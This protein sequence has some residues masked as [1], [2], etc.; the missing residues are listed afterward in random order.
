MG[1]RNELMLHLHELCSTHIFF[2]KHGFPYVDRCRRQP[3]AICSLLQKGYQNEFEI[4]VATHQNSLKVGEA[5][6]EYKGI[7]WQ[8][9][10]LVNNVNIENLEIK[11]AQIF[12]NC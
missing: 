3:F 4:L 7:L 5:L 10:E 2:V 6:K 11:V 9:Q 12:F 1:C 8:I